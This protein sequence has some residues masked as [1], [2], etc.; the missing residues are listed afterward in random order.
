MKTPTSLP[1]LRIRSVPDLLAVIPRLLGFHPAESLTL[2]VVDDGRLAV[3]ARL[4]LAGCST[5]GVHERLAPLWRRYPSALYLAVVHSEDPQRA[6]AGLQALDAAA[7]PGL[8]LHRFHADG[9]RWFD[10]PDAP[11]EPYDISCS[12]VAAHA[13]YEGLTACA[14]RREVE[15]SVRPTA[16]PRQVTRALK[17]LA[18][19]GLDTEGLVREALRLVERADAGDAGPL[20]LT[21]AAVL[22]LASHDLAFREAAILSTSRTNAEGRVALWLAVVQGSAPSCAGYALAILGLAAWVSGQGALQVVCIERAA[23]VATDQEWIEVLDRVNR[24]ALPPSEWDQLR[25]DW[26]CGY[27]AAT[28]S[29]PEEVSL[30]AS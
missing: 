28:A 5:E 22:A 26:Y 15:R 27:L 6:W 17:A 25:A 7:P 2:V 29:G 24:E 9:V 12:A 13:A 20:Q 23:G 4:D 1:T 8:D 19:R 30:D 18:R 21:D 14:S 10:A 3:T 11:G 16:T